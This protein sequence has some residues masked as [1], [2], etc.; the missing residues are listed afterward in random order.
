[1]NGVSQDITPIST[2]P[3]WTKTKVRHVIK[4]VSAVQIIQ[5]RHIGQISQH[6]GAAQ[7]RIAVACREVVESDDIATPAQQ[8]LDHV[9][10]DITRT[11]HYKDTEWVSR[12]SWG[13]GRGLHSEVL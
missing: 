11:A 4:A 13:V 7:H 3:T 6:K 10:A 8:V 9:R 12:R 1:M 5:C 2:S